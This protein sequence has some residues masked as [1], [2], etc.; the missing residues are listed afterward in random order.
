MKTG[1]EE[2]KVSLSEDNMLIFLSDLKHSTRELL[3]MIKIV[4]EV[5]EYNIYSKKKKNKTKQ[6]QKNPKQNHL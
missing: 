1:M 6:K 3:N 2:V 4:S 5:T